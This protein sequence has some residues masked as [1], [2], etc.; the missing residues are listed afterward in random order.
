M[1]KGP[2]HQLL[3]AQYGVVSRAQVLELGLSISAIDRLVASGELQRVLPGVY[4][5]S[6]A[7]E[8]WLQRLMAALLWAGPDAAVS[9]R[10]AGALLGLDG[11]TPGLVEISVTRSRRSLSK[12]VIV[13]CVSKLPA[14]DITRVGVLRVTNA[15]RTLID[16]GGEVDLSTLE[17][18]LE[19]AL[20]QGQTSPPRLRWRL[21]EL[22]V[23]G[24]KG[25]AALSRLLADLDSRR[26]E[27]VLELR[28]EKL[29]LKAGLPRPVRQHEIREGGRVIARIDLAYPESKL[30]IECDGY[31]YHSGKEAWHRDRI[32][33]NELTAR[34]W[35]IIRAT[36]H[37]LETNPEGIVKQVWAALGLKAS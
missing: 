8:S 28:V 34:G 27:S 25:A 33:H 3:A 10:A 19:S 18:A 14:C 31:R 20:R 9:H 24:R 17:A 7:E 36:W 35:R 26:A 30:A 2:L 15:S 32:R 29:L 5:H 6:T 11:I 12:D 1:Q 21:K 4:R 37:D 23:Q 13:H 22:G 16:L